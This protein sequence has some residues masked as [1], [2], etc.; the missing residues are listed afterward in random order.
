M[1]SVQATLPKPSIFSRLLTGRVIRI[2][3]WLALA[4]LAVIVFWQNWGEVETPVLFMTVRMPRSIFILSVLGIGFLLGL[5]T[6][7]PWLRK[8][9]K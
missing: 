8:D 9:S 7:T 1:E 3:C 4:T 5:L 6:L 2:I